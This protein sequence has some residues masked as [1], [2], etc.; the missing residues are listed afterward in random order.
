MATGRQRER[1]MQRIANERDGGDRIARVRDIGDGI[2]WQQHENRKSKT[3][4]VH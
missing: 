2:G 4:R 3:G 1:D